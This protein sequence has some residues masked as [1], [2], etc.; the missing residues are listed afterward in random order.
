MLDMLIIYLTILTTSNKIWILNMKVDD[1]DKLQPKIYF[2]FLFVHVEWII[3][4][5][6]CVFMK[7]NQIGHLM[8]SIT[9]F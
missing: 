8:F 4:H 3:I 6:A 5:I 7:I 2:T 9:V 1:Y